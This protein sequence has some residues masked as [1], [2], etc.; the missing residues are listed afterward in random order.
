MILVGLACLSSSRIAQAENE[1]A[2]AFAELFDGPQ[3][4]GPCKN[5]EFVGNRHASRGI[6]VEVKQEISSSSKEG[7]A[8]YLVS[9]SGKA[10]VGPRVGFKYSIQK[11][12]F[13]SN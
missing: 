5:Y 2:K 9:P 4:C 13:A 6:W 1:D 8:T 10:Q 7:V 12:W 11:A 3:E